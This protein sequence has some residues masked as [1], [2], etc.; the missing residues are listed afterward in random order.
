[1]G[2]GMGDGDLEVETGLDGVLH[3]L[4]RVTRDKMKAAKLT[5]QPAWHLHYSV[6]CLLSL[7]RAASVARRIT[8][9]KEIYA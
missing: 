4:R 9:K 7:L 3:P 5:S 1:M 2:D 8:I 6:N